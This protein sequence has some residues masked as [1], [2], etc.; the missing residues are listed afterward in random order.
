MRQCF[1]NDGNF[2]DG[3]DHTRRL[4]RFLP[5]GRQ[6]LPGVYVCL[7]IRGQGFYVLAG[8]IVRLADEAPTMRIQGSNAPAT[9]TPSSAPRRGS[10]ASGFSVPTEETAQ[11]T[12]TSSATLRTIGG[13]DALIAMQSED[14]VGGRRRRAIKRGRAALDALDELKHGMLA[15]T[16]SPS[17][18]LRLKSAATELK[19]ASGESGLDAVLA[20][21]ELRIEVEI[22]KLTP[23]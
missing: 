7:T 22:A 17:T 6:Y 15:G 23:R 2:F 5:D 4:G 11:Q 9:V 16:L 18:L 1:E 20:E 3:V 19:G 10:A 14:E 8:R 13:I 21:I 12:V